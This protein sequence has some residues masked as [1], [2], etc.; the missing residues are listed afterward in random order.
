MKIRFRRF[1]F[2]LFLW[3]AS[4]IFLGWVGFDH[5]ADYSEYLRDQGKNWI[6]YAYD[7]E[8]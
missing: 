3:L 7:W 2:E 6:V 8:F 5:L 1:T 4:E